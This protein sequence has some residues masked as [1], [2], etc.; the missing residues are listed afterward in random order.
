MK[1]E[2]ILAVSMINGYL[3]LNLWKIV[4]L[5]PENIHQKERDHFIQLY[6]GEIES[7][8]FRQGNLPVGRVINLLTRRYMT[9]TEEEKIAIINDGFPIQIVPINK[10]EDLDKHK[11]MKRPSDDEYTRRFEE[12]HENWGRLRYKE[13]A[14]LMRERSSMIPERERRGRSEPLPLYV[15]NEIHHPSIDGLKES[16]EFQRDKTIGYAIME[17]WLR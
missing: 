15:R 4:A 7:S 13:M 2:L 17:N 1:P 12:L 10:A 11:P 14:R 16:L 6:L 8:L 3:Q 5:L 9:Q